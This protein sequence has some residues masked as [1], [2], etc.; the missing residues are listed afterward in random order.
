MISHILL[1]VSLSTVRVVVEGQSGAPTAPGVGGKPEKE[2]GHPGW[3]EEA[4]QAVR[5]PVS[6]GTGRFT[7]R[8]SSGRPLAEYHWWPGWSGVLSKNEPGGP[9]VL[10]NIWRVLSPPRCSEGSRWLP[11]ASSATGTRLLD[12]HCSECRSLLTRKRQR[13][14]CPG[15]WPPAVISCS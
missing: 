2:G 5:W 12:T 7:G 6:G 4:P 11:P 15:T 13:E 3:R 9:G 10:S 8:H 1:G 14:Y